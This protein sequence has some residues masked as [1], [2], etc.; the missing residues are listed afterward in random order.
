MGLRVD[1]FDKVIGKVLKAKDHEK[2]VHTAN[3]IRE[4]M[5]Y[6]QRQLDM[7]ADELK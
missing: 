5:E 4:H 7:L 3:S 1:W 6:L 2:L